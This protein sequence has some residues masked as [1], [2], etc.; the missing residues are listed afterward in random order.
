VSNQRD[1]FEDRLGHQLGRF[2]DTGLPTKGPDEVALAAM[3][4]RRRGS[5]AVPLAIGLLALAVVVTLQVGGLGEI[6]GT[7]ASTTSVVPSPKTQEPVLE[8]VSLS[9]PT[10]EAAKALGLCEVAGR[11]DQVA[12]MA[13][14]THA[15][16][17]PGYAPLTGR[18]P[19]IQTSDAAWV[20]AYRGLITFTSRSQAGSIEMTDPTCA[21]IDG[22][23]IWFA[24][25]STR[26]SDGTTVTPEPVAST[27]L[28]PLPT[29]SP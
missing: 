12:G 22:V 28:L 6:G 9:R 20:V 5:R 10:A 14:L 11:E 2:A 24:T 19:E 23:P 18:E 8:P 25:G 16:D 13:L 21:V 1:E 27:E 4:A 26:S 7:S 15:S 29:L 3:Q 17:L